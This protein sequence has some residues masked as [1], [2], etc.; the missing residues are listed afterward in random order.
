MTITTYPLC[1]PPGWP[2]CQTPQHSRFETT[3]TAARA[4]LLAELDRL[5]AR[6]VVV[7]S[8]A[9][10][11][12]SGDLAGRQ[13]YLEDT[14]VAVY[15]VLDGQQRVIPCDKWVRLGD[16]LR[17]IGLTVNALRGLDRWGTPGIVAAAFAGFH[18]LP[19]G[20]APDGV[21]WWQVLELPPNADAA[22][23]KAAYRVKARAT[24]PDVGG[25]RTAFER[26]TAAY[27]QGLRGLAG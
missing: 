7:S 19:A 6:D 12:K 9:A 21:P 11:L 26:L 23:I 15:F 2:R 16:N 8:N 5:G 20:P 27:D 17:A 3:P 18:A 13:P 22:A 25:D 10:L 24:H 14:G 4:H 1:W